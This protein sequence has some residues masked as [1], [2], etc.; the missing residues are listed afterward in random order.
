M[1][2]KFIVRDEDKNE[3]EVEE[4]EETKDGLEEVEEKEELKDDASLSSEEIDALKK[5]ASIADKLVDLV[6]IEKDEHAGKPEEEMLDEDEDEEEIE[7]DEEE[8]VD[9]DEELDK[10][11][12]Q[13]S[14][15]SVGSIAKRAK[16]KDSIADAQEL[17]VAAAWAKRYGGNK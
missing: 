2:K 14:K 16:S 13:D 6:E 8:I 1:K 9:T 7:E 3:F 5:L 15:K 11:K 10:M 12:G 17:D 4:V